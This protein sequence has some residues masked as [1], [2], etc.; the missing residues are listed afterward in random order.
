MGLYRGLHERKQH[1]TDILKNEAVLLEHCYSGLFEVADK[2][3][4][5]GES[6]ITVE[7]YKT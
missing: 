3:I 4:Q 5:N 2:K 1:I 6:N 7:V